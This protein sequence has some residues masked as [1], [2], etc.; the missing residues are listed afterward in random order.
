MLW[1]YG[2]V[3]QLFDPRRLAIGVSRLGPFLSSWRRYRSLPGAEGAAF[4]DTIPQLHDRTTTT[5]FD[6]HYFYVNA[7]AMRR[8]ARDNPGYHVDVGSHTS[9]ASLLAAVVPV[10]FLDYRPLRA[11]VPGLT[12]LSGSVL[13][14]PFRTASLAS[15]SCLHVAE[16]I[17]LG[18]YGDRL[19]PDGTRKAARELTRVVAPG[20]SLYFAVPVGRPRVCFNAHRIH[21]ASAIR[22]YFSDLV[23]AAYGG[24]DDTG[25][26]HP[27]LPVDALDRCDYGCGLFWFRKP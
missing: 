8:V 22:G 15:V 10:V 23:L 25:A 24:V 12:C 17:G 1:A 16:H 9:F 3:Q 2:W 4:F 18:R 14:L 11:S 6:P 5:T 21:T 26:F 27:E 7:W 19:D 13:D 20:G